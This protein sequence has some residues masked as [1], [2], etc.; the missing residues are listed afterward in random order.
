[1]DTE[2]IVGAVLLTLTISLVV[3]LVRALSQKK[4][5]LSLV[6][7]LTRD[8]QQIGVVVVK[9][10]QELKTILMVGDPRN[11]GKLNTV[12][13]NLEEILPEF[14]KDKICLQCEEAKKAG[15]RYCPS[16]GKIQA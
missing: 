5:A 3:F 9:S 7:N 2:H 15:Q 16:C 8:K 11:Q 12:I 6:T 13:K 4:E 1:M 14:G 10:T